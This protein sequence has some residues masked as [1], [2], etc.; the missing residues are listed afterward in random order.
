MKLPNAPTFSPVRLLQDITEWARKVVQAFNSSADT[1]D[2]IY[3]GTNIIVGTNTTSDVIAGGGK[4]GNESGGDYS[5]F[6]DDGTLIFHGDATVWD[7]LR[8]EPTVKSA[9]TNDP[10]YS[11]WLDNGSGSRGVSLYDFT[12]VITASQKEIYFTAQLPHAWKGTVIYPHVHW[13]PG[14]A[15]SSQRPVWG[16]E[17]TWADIGTVFGNTTIIYTNALVPNDTNLVQNKHYISN[18]SSGITPST[19]QDGISSVLICRLFRYSGDAS[20][21][22]TGTCGLM[23]ID[24]H[25]EIDTL[26]SRSEY[27]K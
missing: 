17:Y 22:F 9:G 21:T 18:F 27:T 25:F 12:D 3:D 26:G 5:E 6:E 16:L 10:T 13:I 2:N 11:K 15:G 4:F 8:V 23:Y 1:L 19:S 14:A 20:D 24:I 7:D